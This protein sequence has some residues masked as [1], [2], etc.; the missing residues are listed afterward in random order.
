MTGWLSG[1]LAAQEQFRQ[2]SE[3]A[4]ARKKYEDLLKMKMDDQVRLA[5]LAKVEQDRY[6]EEKLYSRLSDAQKFAL[7]QQKFELDRKKATSPQGKWNEEVGGWVYEPDEKNPNGRI[8]K[9]QGVQPKQSAP[10]AIPSGYQLSPDG[11][12]LIAV[13]GGP[14]DPEA[15]EQK[16][17]P[18]D[19]QAKAYGY[20]MRMLNSDNLL[21]GN[22]NYSPFGV[23]TLRTYES[24]PSPGFGVGNAALRAFLSEDTLK[25]DQAQRDFINAILRRESGA[26]ISDSEFDNANKQYFDQVNDPDS[27]KRQKAL[28]RKLAIEGLRT[29]SGKL[30]EKLPTYEE[31]ASLPPANNKGWPLH[32]DANGNKAYVG[33]NGEIEEVR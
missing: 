13:R 14:A 2:S 23:N 3:D 15:L 28:N 32:V 26:V 7:D 12:S 5:D 17:P 18:T 29:A 9:A 6:N 22:K 21:R 30:S 24:L 1:Y 16:K 11:K 19:E 20:A 8:V 27:V 33:P 4:F 31:M 25:A 10:F